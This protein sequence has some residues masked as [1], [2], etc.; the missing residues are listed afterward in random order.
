MVRNYPTCCQ[1][2]LGLV[3]KRLSVQAL[4]LLSS[5]LSNAVLFPFDV[6]CDVSSS[7]FSLNFFPWPALSTD[8]INPPLLCTLLASHQSLENHKQFLSTYSTCPSIMIHHRLRQPSSLDVCA[9]VTSY[10]AFASPPLEPFQTIRPSS[11]TPMRNVPA[12]KHLHS[13]WNEKK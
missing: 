10:P 12:S 3:I 11:P 5:L 13:T 7:P 2:C 4:G 6:H 1:V 9:A 8:A